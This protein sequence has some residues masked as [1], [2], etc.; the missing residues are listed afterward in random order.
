MQNASV[1]LI[2]CFPPCF[3]F[4]YETEDN[5]IQTQV[6]DSYIIK[7]AAVLSIHNDFLTLYCQFACFL[8]KTLPKRLKFNE[9]S[10]KMLEVR[11]KSTRARCKIFPQLI[12]MTQNTANFVVLVSLLLPFNMSS[13]LSQFFYFNPEQVNTG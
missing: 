3:Q 11:K 1:L 4:Y 12:N 13:A 8:C 10:I 6:Y 5:S 2:L 9:I 7:V